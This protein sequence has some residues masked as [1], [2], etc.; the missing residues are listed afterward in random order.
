MDG[1]ERHIV[2]HGVGCDDDDGTNDARKRTSA[3]HVIFYE[4]FDVSTVSTY[5]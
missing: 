5:H 2:G 3:R 4:L 1:E